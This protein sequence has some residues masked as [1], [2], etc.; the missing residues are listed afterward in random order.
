LTYRSRRFS[1]AWWFL[2]AAT[3]VLVQVS[4]CGEVSPPLAALPDAGAWD[5]AIHLPEAST[6]VIEVDADSCHPGDVSTYVAPAYHSAL[7]TPDA[8]GP[9]GQGS[10]IQQFYEACFGPSATPTQ[11][12]TYS[13]SYASCAACMVTPG[14][15]DHYGPY[16]D[17]GGALL[18]NVA[19]CIE[20]VDPS[21]AA[22]ACAKALQAQVGCERAACA[23]NCPVHDSASLSS[24]EACAAAADESGC[25][26][27]GVAS[28]CA[29]VQGDAGP[30]ALCFGSSQDYFNV[31]APFFCGPAAHV[32]GAADGSAAGDLDAG[33]GSDAPGPSR[34]ADR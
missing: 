1:R 24:Y 3:G 14:T 25:Q 30:A 34:D 12:T 7:V 18:P 27:F 20:L 17:V 5:G 4:A 16:V 21:A 15:A 33:A 29:G 23:A 28:A 19:G 31:A 8:C 32:T 6:T 2:A 11:C 9:L 13:L 10:S 26:V 22:L